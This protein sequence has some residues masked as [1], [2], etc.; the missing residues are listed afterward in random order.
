MTGKKQIGIKPE[1]W[2]I[3]KYKYILI[4]VGCIVFANTLM[5]GYNMDDE[6]V[7]RNHP[8]T[9]QGVKAIGE[10]FSSSYYSD[11]MGYAYGYRPIVHLSFA[12]E[13][14]FFGEKAEVSHLIN[15]ILY[16]AGVLTLFKVLARWF[17]KDQLKWA[18][19]AAL[20]FL[21][22]PVHVEVVA[23]IKNRDELLAFLFA[24]MSALLILKYAE[25][26]KG[27][28]W[29]L[30]AILFFGIGMLAK[31]SIYPLVVVFPI[32]SLLLRN[33]SV[34]KV[35]FMSLGL[36]IPGALIAAEMQ[37]ERFVVAI[38]V[39]LLAIFGV[40][41]WKRLELS[42]RDVIQNTIVLSVISWGVVLIGIFNSDF[43]IVLAGI[44][45]ALS[46]V[47]LNARIGV[48]QIIIQTGI[49]GAFWFYTDFSAYSFLI[50]LIYSFYVHHKNKKLDLLFVILVCVSG[51]VYFYSTFIG[52]EMSLGK[53]IIVFVVLL[54]LS[55]FYF[56]KT[57]VAFSVV[58]LLIVL[59]I[60]FW[61]KVWAE[62]GFGFL[63]N[64]LVLLSVGALFIKEKQV[65]KQWIRYVP[66]VAFI[67][68]LLGEKELYKHKSSADSIQPVAEWV[69]NSTIHQSDSEIREGRQLEYVENTLVAPHSSE[70]K[71]ATGFS[72]LGNYIQLMGFP[73]ELSF[74]YGYAK[75]KTENVSSITVW[76]SIIIHLGLVILA[77]L[78]LNKRP[79]ITIG[80]VWY[81]GCI[82]LFSNWI[83]LVAGMVGERLVFV[84]SAGFSLFIIAVFRWSNP[85]MNMKKPG[86][87]GFLLMGILIV[88]T[89]RT[90]VR[91]ADWK[92][93]V[94]LMRH[95]IIHLDHSA[96]AHNLLATN[97]MKESLDNTRLLPA[98]RLAL[99]R[100]AYHHF[101]RATEVWPYFFNAWYDRGRV[102]TYLG[103][104]KEA[105]FSFEKVLELDST[106]LPAY[107]AALDAYDRSGDSQQYLNTARELLSY[108]KK[109][110][111]YELLARGYYLNNKIDSALY[112]LGVGID[113]FPEDEGLRSNYMHIRDLE[114]YNGVTD[115]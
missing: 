24:V 108:E 38:V 46:I 47:F 82:L 23:S 31:K 42:F 5:N 40:Y 91:N 36:I 69:K 76:L 103:E 13:H 59:R 15:L 109:E 78:M 114:H 45:I 30:L 19:L 9:S 49:I 32:A 68:L 11:E 73:A 1:F 107:Y 101:V 51:A 35:I 20:L 105:S 71:I 112:I 87:S 95:D 102:A 98:N 4:I 86:V 29:L 17:E 44:L 7:T 33:L 70:E 104:W 81:L 64:S 28:G 16:L 56:F 80:I 65:L 88:F 72:V 90:I 62:D 21:I 79:L 54:Y 74:Y 37:W 12:I 106:F 85:E 58:I 77:F 55:L 66:I 93:A 43:R 67:I 10:I 63:M 61:H 3:R 96:Q 2:T 50:A 48:L 99:Q 84:A 34:R 94:T 18:F 92:D 8:L 113:L 110:G 27:M 57:W 75:V 100:E 52:G 26:D 115:R 25:K 53:M 39:P 83:E 97:L 41:Y 6:L 111:N 14:A 60:L 89:G 22:H